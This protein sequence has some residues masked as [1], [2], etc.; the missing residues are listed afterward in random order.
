M[1]VRP[2][3]LPPEPLG[4]F[5]ARDLGWLWRLLSGATCCSPITCS[6]TGLLSFF[7]TRV[8]TGKE[9]LLPFKM[10]E[11]LEI[12]QQSSEIF[13]SLQK[14]DTAVPL[15]RFLSLLSLQRE[16]VVK[17]K[18][19]QKSEK[20]DKQFLLYFHSLPGAEAGKNKLN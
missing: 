12:S 1:H 14:G 17:K 9:N 13:C 10:P 3:F 15:H 16:Q 11:K 5:G 2:H 8:C 6:H 18:G 19:K 7:N 20:N 4:A